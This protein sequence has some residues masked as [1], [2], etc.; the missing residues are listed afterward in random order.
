VLSAFS[1]KEFAKRVAL[2]LIQSN[3]LIAYEDLKVKN[4]VKSKLAKS[5][6][7]AAW[8]EF[9]QWVEYFAYKYG[10]IAVAVSPYNTSQDCSNCGKKVQK[11]LSTRTHVCPHCQTVLDR[12]VNAAINILKRGL[13]ASST[14]GHEGSHACGESTST[15][16]GSDLLRQVVSAKQESPSL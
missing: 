2:R 11:T 1:R 16:V 7:D 8:S 4:L 10:R 9:R 6:N 5:I 13:S 14:S 12:D 15:L 3:D